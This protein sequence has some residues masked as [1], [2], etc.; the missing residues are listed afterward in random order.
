MIHRQSSLAVC[1]ALAAAAM[2]FAAP[3]AAQPRAPAAA[4][5][6]VQPSAIFQQ[7]A[8][9]LIEV[10]NGQRNLASIAATPS[11]GK[12]TKAEVSAKVARM[13][14]TMRARAGPAL[15]IDRIVAETPYK[16]DVYVN[17][18]KTQ[19]RVPLTIDAEAPHKLRAFSIQ[20]APAARRR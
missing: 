12:P 4:A 5:Q 20:S 10:Y 11:P 18:Q 16:G 2:V 3:C 13:F 9:E 14:H 15:G 17:L 1:G 19:V 8:E 7:R 6:A